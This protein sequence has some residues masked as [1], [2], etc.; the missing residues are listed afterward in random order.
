[1]DIIVNAW[2]Q[3]EARAIFISKSTGHDACIDTMD[4]SVNGASDGVLPSG[5]SSWSVVVSS[6]AQR[7]KCLASEEPRDAGGEGTTAR[8]LPSHG[9][10]LAV[11]CVVSAQLPGSGRVQARVWHSFRGMGPRAGRIHSGR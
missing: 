6:C 1:M 11:G 9:V 5:T 10:A 3:E 4:T 2:S 7:R 8:R